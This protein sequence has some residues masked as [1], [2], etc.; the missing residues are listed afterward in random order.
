LPG[1]VSLFETVEA[2]CRE[3]ASAF[4]I[5]GFTDLDE[6]LS[7]KPSALVISTPPALHAQYVRRALDLN[8]S[9]FAEVP[10][11]LDLETLSEVSSR[12]SSFPGVLG[13]SHTIR[14]YPPFRLIHDL[15]RQGAVGKVL[16]L[17]YSMGN[18]LPDWHP[19][20]DY[21]KFYAGDVG[22]GGAGMDMILHEM[23]VIQWWLGRIESVTARLTKVSELEIKG[24]DNHDVLFSFAG[25]SRGFF[26]DDI[27]ERGT[28]GRHIRIAGAEG[29]L[30][31]HQN[32]ST[33]RLFEAKK[34]TNLQLG[35]DQASDWSEALNASREMTAILA[36]QKAKSG[37]IPSAA[38]PGF[39]YESCY[40]REMRHFLGAV[41]GKHPYSMSNPQE[42]L[43][44][45]RVF[46]AFCKSSEEKQEV[47]L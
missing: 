32:L 31:W 43:A 1:E 6:A 4:G 39:T 8:L 41:Q 18:Y 9:V 11:A 17:E 35:F 2:R 29:T 44:N 26:H 27:I 15:L 34:K 22:L 12:A 25:G 37:A 19:Y 21:R 24:P 38:T 28:V 42:E 16:Y 13:V 3:T 7:E 14:Y 30:E 20:E 5:R 40:L 46:H 45:V 47:L 10:F 36:K 33:I 23:S